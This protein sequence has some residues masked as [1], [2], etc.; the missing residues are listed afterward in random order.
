MA[1]VRYF[2]EQSN[3]AWTK[4]DT[5]LIQPLSEEGCQSCK[6]FQSGAGDLATNGRRFDQDPVR[7]TSLAVR[8]GAPEGRVFLTAHLHQTSAHVIDQ[9]GQ[10]TSTQSA[11]DLVRQI[12]VIW[13]GDRWL[14]YGMAE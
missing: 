1:F 13:M 5:T 8:P 7:L 14:L 11:E 6:A 12:A 2:I 9:T 10:I 3:L 4:P